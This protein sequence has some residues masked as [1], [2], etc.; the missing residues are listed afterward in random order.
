MTK[1]ISG[2]PKCRD[3]QLSELVRGW[4][5][6]QRLNNAS[7]IQADPK[8]LSTVAALSTKYCSC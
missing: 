6:Q 1:T 8:D 3:T 5:H 2:W 4:W 7:L